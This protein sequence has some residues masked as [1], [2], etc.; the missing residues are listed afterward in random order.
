MN[1]IATRLKGS[2]LLLPALALLVLAPAHLAQA[3]TT[4]YTAVLTGAAESPPN[5]SP[6]TGTAQVDYDDVANTLHV[7]V[8]FSG[9]TGNTTASHIHAA[10][11]VAG[12]GTAGVAT[13][14]PTFAGFPLGVTAGT[15]DNTLDLTQAS[16]FS[17]TFIT[18]HTNVAGAAAFMLS[19]IAAGTAY[20]NVHSSTF[21]GGEIRGFL[22]PVASTP[23]RASTWGMLKTLYR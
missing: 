21:G 11:A 12:T 2:R 15:Y 13:T 18:A 16:S 9:L 7:H 3:A 22:T 14:L 6:G 5:A 20:L 4:S 1:A 19:S 23:A 10:T 8:V 17:A